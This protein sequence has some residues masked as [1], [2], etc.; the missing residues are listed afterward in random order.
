MITLYETILNSTGS[1]TKKLS[2]Y[3]ITALNSN[4]NLSDMFDMDKMY[5]DVE[6]IY[7]KKPQYHTDAVFAI[8]ANKPFLKKDLK[9]FGDKDYDQTKKNTLATEVFREMLKDYLKNDK[10]NFFVLKNQYYTYSVGCYIDKKYNTKK[11]I[12]IFNF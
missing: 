8:I 12:G 2:A 11:T 7:G 5:D 9:I 10:I 4:V 1:G 3:D 6:K